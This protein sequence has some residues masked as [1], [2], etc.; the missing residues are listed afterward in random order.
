MY[1]E[2]TC[3]ASLIAVLKYREQHALLLK[4]FAPPHI[5]EQFET[6]ESETDTHIA[7][8]RSNLIT[9]G[10]DVEEVERQFAA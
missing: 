6:D 8:H 5:R 1:E 7:H 4:K 2:F 9:L 3:F 10:I